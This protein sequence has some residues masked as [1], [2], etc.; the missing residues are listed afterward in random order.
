LAQGSRH[1]GVRGPLSPID[2]R[3]PE[4]GLHGRRLP[5]PRCAQAR[6]QAFGLQGLRKLQRKMRSRFRCIKNRGIRLILCDHCPRVPFASALSPAAHAGRRP[7]GTCCL[8]LKRRLDIHTPTRNPLLVMWVKAVTWRTPQ[9]ECSQS[10]YIVTALLC[11]RSH[12][13]ARLG[14]SEIGRAHV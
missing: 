5:I 11:Q 3:Q 9:E 7:A 4:G 6:P 14:I 2:S 8:P 10:D 1:S 12:R 13:A